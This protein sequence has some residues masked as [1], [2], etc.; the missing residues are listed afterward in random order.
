[1]DTHERAWRRGLAALA[2]LVMA[3]GL[4][5]CGSSDDDGGGETAAASTGGTAAATSEAAAPSEDKKPVKLAMELTL[6]G[7]KFGQDTKAGIEGFVEED[8]A[9]ELDVQGPPSIDPVTAQKQLTDMLAKNPDAV[10][11]APFPPELWQ[12]TLTTI[13]QRF[14][15]ASLTFNIKP[16]GKVEDVDKAPIQTFVGVD[17]TESAREVLRKTIELAGLGPDTTG[18]AII[19]QCVAGETGVLYERTQG[20]KQVFA[21][22][23]PEVEVHEFDS[24]VEPQANTNAWTAELAANPDPVLA[25]GTCD[26]DGTSLYKIKKQRGYTFPVG[27]VETPPEVVAGIKDG[28]ILASSAVNW[29]LEGYTAAR[30]LAEAARGAEMPKG[31]VDI[32]T[33]LI[34]KDNIDEIEKRDSSL[35]ETKAWYAPKIEELFA[36]LPAHTHPMQDAWK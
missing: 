26:Q 2:A 25:I 19:G 1:M 34:T 18:M 32:G 24:K 23:L 27:A 14:P 21:E 29:Y 3:A 30:L 20:F 8:G 11:V 35:A 9:V 22:L 12:R 4:A 5:A 17:D 6:T 16:A 7:V 15:D 33:T 31:F 13:H 36:D 10:G 28:S